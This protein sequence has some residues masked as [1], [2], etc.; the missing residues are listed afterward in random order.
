MQYFISTKQLSCLQI[1]WSEFLLRFNFIIQYQPGKLGAKPNALTR[2]LENLYKEED[3]RLQQMVQTVLKLHNLDST[4]KKDLFAAP[5]VIEGEEY[6]NDLI[7]E[8]LIDCGYK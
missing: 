8:Q 2:R 1:C 3:G 7:L 4:I 5:L 6:L